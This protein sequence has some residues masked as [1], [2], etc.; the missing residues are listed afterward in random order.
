MEELRSTSD[1]FIIHII[2]QLQYLTLE[3]VGFL[4][5]L[6]GSGRFAG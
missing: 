4:Y 2:T 1:N 6:L 3:L 5:L